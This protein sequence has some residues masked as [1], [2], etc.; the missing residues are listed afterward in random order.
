VAFQYLKKAFKKDGWRL[1]YS[2]RSRYNGLKLEKD[3]F[4]LGIRKKFLTPT[5]EEL[6]LDDLSLRSL[7]GLAILRSCDSDQVTRTSCVCLHSSDF[8]SIRTNI[9]LIDAENYVNS[10]LK[11]LRLFVGFRGSLAPV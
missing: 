9:L 11:F 5:S 4:R 1:Y 6:E 7:P 8:K 3:T 10:T 2:S